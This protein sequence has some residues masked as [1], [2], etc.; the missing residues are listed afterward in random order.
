MAS[1]DTIGAYK[2]NN[3]TF[4]HNLGTG[5]APEGIHNSYIVYDLFSEMSWRQEPIG[6]LHSWF[7]EYAT[8]R[9]GQVNHNAEEAWKILS[10][11]VYNSTVRNFHGRVLMI[12]EP[13][14][15][16]KELRYTF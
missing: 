8:R 6:D 15:K 12:K 2:I 11:N 9:Y 13:S 5:M 1:K 3:T 10:T 16:M 7:G 14:L 4:Y